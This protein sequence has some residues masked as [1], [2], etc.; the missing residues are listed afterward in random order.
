MTKA[1]VAFLILAGSAP[2]AGAEAAPAQLA[3]LEKYAT[4]AKATDPSF[5]GFSGERGKA[6]FF[7][8]PAA[9]KPDTPSC[10][11]CH[12]KNPKKPGR[13]RAG[14]E[15]G[16]E[17][18]IRSLQRQPGDRKVVRPQLRQRAWAALHTR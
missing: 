13:T 17:R 5:G 11:T 1:A 7:S 14:K 18:E 12:T 16:A 3:I 10:T 4:E 9:G 15:I 8:E 2:L 6:F